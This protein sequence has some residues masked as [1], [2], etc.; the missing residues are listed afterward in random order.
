MLFHCYLKFLTIK[1]QGRLCRMVGWLLVKHLLDRAGHGFES[2]FNALQSVLQIL[3][4]LLWRSPLGWQFGKHTF[5]IGFSASTARLDAITLDLCPLN[6]SR[7][8]FRNFF[9]CP[10]LSLS[11]FVACSADLYALAATEGFGS[12]GE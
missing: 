7:H 5:C 3:H 2:L 8:L 1:R 9:A 10:H 4:V 12:Q 11:T 6:V